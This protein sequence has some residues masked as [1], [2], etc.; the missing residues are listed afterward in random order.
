MQDFFNNILYADNHLVVAFKPPGM[1][2]QRDSSGDDSILEWVARYLKAKYHKPGDVFVGSVH[3]L[4]RPARGL[5]LFA[6]TSKSHTRLLAQF[7]QAQVEKAYLAVVEGRPLASEGALEH[8]LWKD[9]QKN[10][11]KVFNRPGEGRKKARL[12]YEW[13]GE[14]DK[15][16]LLRIYLETGRPHQIR[17]QLASM[18]CPIKG[19]VKYGASHALQDRSICL[20]AAWLR[21]L[22]PVRREKMQFTAAYPVRED[23]WNM[24]EPDLNWP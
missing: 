15:H 4:D 17:T 11:V 18:G 7:R 16:S 23:Y 19:D 20:M 5:M 1:L 8:F 12:K 3:R 22:H 21:F 13:L 6:K 14:S 2:S 9:T 10:L 24:F